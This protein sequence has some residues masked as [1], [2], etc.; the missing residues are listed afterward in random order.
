V[1]L[2]GFYYKNKLTVKFRKNVFTQLSR[3]LKSIF[4]NIRIHHKWLLPLLV[5]CRQW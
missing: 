3:R 1:Y 5:K 2:V 4:L